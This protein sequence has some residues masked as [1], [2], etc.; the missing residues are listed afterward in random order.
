MDVFLFKTQTHT[1][2]HTHTHTHTYRE[3]E[4]RAIHPRT[5]CIWAWKDSYMS[6]GLCQSSQKRAARRKGGRSE[7]ATIDRSTYHGR[8]EGCLDQFVIV[9]AVV[10]LASVAWNCLGLLCLLAV[11]GVRTASTTCASCVGT[12]LSNPFCFP[13]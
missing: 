2:K 1:Q 7:L 8:R 5:S 11:V 6:L 4:R 3:R 9:V 13:P 12:L 10:F